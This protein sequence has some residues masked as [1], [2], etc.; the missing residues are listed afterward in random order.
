RYRRA[1][2]VVRLPECE[3]GNALPVLFFHTGHPPA[4][5]PRLDRRRRRLLRLGALGNLRPRLPPRLE[6]FSPPRRHARRPAVLL[7]RPPARRAHARPPRRYRAASLAA[8]NPE[9]S[10][11]RPALQGQY[12]PP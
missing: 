11:R 7:V 5:I 2:H 12:H 3:P 4:Q 10:R 9:I 6:S 8:E 1:A